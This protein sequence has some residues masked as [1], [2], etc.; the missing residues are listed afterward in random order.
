MDSLAGQLSR[1]RLLLELVLYRVVTLR[2]LLAGGEGRFLTWAADELERAVERL[3]E[4]E[5]QRAAVVAT[6]A[7]ELATDP[8]QLTLARLAERCEEPWRSVFTEHRVAFLRLTEE[9]EAQLAVARRLAGVGQQAVAE[10]LE[11]LSGGAGQPEY[12]GAT[13][14]PSARWD[15]GGAAPRVLRTL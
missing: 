10:M 13:Y 4:A 2:Q 11:K 12:A 1:E 15:R 8:D 6:V 9:V 7:R 3:R 5:L 14:G